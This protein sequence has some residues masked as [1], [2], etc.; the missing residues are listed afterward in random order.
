V[1]TSPVER[2]YGPARGSKYSDQ[3]GPTPS[4]LPEDHAK[5]REQ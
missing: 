5:E 4:R 1:L 3:R 2:P